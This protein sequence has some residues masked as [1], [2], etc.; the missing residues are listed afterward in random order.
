MASKIEQLKNTLKRLKEK[1]TALDKQIVTAEKTL[2]AAETAEKKAKEKAKEKVSK[3]VKKA[4][5]KAAGAKKAV[6][7]KIASLKKK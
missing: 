7:S 4:T 2:V 5:G 3:V 6:A 1:K